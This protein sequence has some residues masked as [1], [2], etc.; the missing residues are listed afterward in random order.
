MAELGANGVEAHV[1]GGVDD[2]GVFVLDV[3][4]ELDVSNFE[5]VRSKVDAL[6]AAEPR[7]V[8][9]DLGSLSFMD[10]SGIALLVGIGNRVDDLRV[11]NPTPVVRRII[12]VCGLADAVG[13]HP[14]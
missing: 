5:V 6:L 11:R 12:E 4:G 3:G 8:V 2:Q 9:V 13:L 1:D 14:V 10:S 7:S